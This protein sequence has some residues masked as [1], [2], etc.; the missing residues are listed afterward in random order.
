MTDGTRE[1]FDK[2]GHH[3]H[4]RSL[5]KATGTLLFDLKDDGHRDRWLV[6]LDKGDIK[7]SHKSGIADAII[8]SSRDTFEELAG[9]RLN[10]MAA[11]L[12][13]AMTVEGD[14]ELLVLFQRLFPGP[15]RKKNQPTRRRTKGKS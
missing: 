7:V 3:G 2:L 4:E 11:L 12:R 13:G 15:K 1:F 14:P 8:R 6:S 5:E 10:A 9:G